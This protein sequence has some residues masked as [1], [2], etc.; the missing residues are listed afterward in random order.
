MWSWQQP[1]GH[2]LGS[3]E[4]GGRA[5]RGPAFQAS[6]RRRASNRSKVGGAL[7]AVSSSH[8]TSAE[9]TNEYLRAQVSIPLRQEGPKSRSAQVW[10]G[11]GSITS[12]TK[13]ARSPHAPMNW[14]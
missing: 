1:P 13:S 9:T 2:D 8:Q 10:S 7:F 3:L 5:L 6:A 11:L 4:G 12:R 14:R